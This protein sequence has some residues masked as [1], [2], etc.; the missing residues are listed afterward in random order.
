MN[1][2]NQQVKIFC[3]KSKSKGNGHFV[4]SE[5]LNFFLKKKKF[6]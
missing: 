3:E 5:R 2:L 4:R 6:K 1:Y